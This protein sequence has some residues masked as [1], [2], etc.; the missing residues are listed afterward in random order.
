MMNWFKPEVIIAAIIALGGMGATV[1]LNWNAGNVNSA[2]SDWTLQQLQA[3]V[4]AIR[5]SLVTVNQDHFT[6]AGLVM[7]QGEQKGYN[8]SVD[9]SIRVIHDDVEK[10]KTTT[11]DLKKASGIKLRGG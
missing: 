10:L 11:E 4:K 2:H 3:D 8:G 5:E 1:A 9:G 7:W 6:V